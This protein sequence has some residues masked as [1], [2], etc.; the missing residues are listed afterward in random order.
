MRFF[1][2]YLFSVSVLLSCG[3]SSAELNDR[4]RDSI[5]K[6]SDTLPQPIPLPAENHFNALLDLPANWSASPIDS[7][8]EVL[9]QASPEQLAAHIATPDNRLSRELLAY[10]LHASVWAVRYRNPGYLK[11]GIKALAFENGHHYYHTTF[12]ALALLE[13][14]AR[15]LK[16]DADRLFHAATH[17]PA[18]HFQQLLQHYRSRSE[19]AREIGVFGYVQIAHP[20]FDYVFQPLWVDT[21]RR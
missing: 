15:L 18:P 6:A 8:L 17:I 16:T 5:A 11:N 21:L 13:H 12:V 20:D 9:G 1:L 3:P 19:K 10:G 4:R 2:F 7:L 14:S